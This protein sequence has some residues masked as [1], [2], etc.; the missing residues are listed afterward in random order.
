MMLASAPATMCRNTR[1]IRPRRTSR[2]WSRPRSMPLGQRLADSEEYPER[3][4]DSGS[5]CDHE[6]R[7]RLLM[8]RTEQRFH[9]RRISPS[10]SSIAL[11]FGL[12]VRRAHSRC[13]SAVIQLMAA[14][15]RLDDRVHFAKIVRSPFRRASTGRD[16]CKSRK[17]TEGYGF[18]PR[19]NIQISKI[20]ET[21]KLP[22]TNDQTGVVSCSPR[23]P[24]FRCTPAPPLSV[25]VRFPKARWA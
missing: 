13:E 19:G 1:P 20:A 3:N 8:R 9:E 16:Y 15:T 24:I 11:T 6:S 21:S 5:P 14:D 10:F 7:F 12:W 4:G 22:A 23:P 2:R 18:I 17:I 25:R